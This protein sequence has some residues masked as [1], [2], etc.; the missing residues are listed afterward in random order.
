[1]I[2]KILIP[3]IVGGIIGYITNDIAIKMLFHPRK[4]IYI[5]KYQ[6]PFTPGLIPKE[7]ERIAKSLGRII[8][9]QLLNNETMVKAL[10]SEEMIQKLR[11]GIEKIIE[12]NKSN[13]STV[14]EALSKLIPE[15][16]A[17]KLIVAIKDGA[18][19]VIYGKITNI[20][21]S[22]N[23]SRNILE[24]L[25]EKISI[26]KLGFFAAMINDDIMELIAQNIAD[27][28]NQYIRENGKALIEE[29]IGTE[30]DKIKN[31]PI[32]EIIIKY[33]DKLPKLIDFI[34]EQ[35][36]SFIAK[37]LTSILKGIDLAKVVEEKISEFSME[38]FE[39]MIFAIMKKELNAIVYFGAAL[40]FV[41]GWIQ[42][43]LNGI[44]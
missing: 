14:E 13:T 36:K 32:N 7:R 8:S 21:V 9:E 16:M 38:Q 44:L 10:A 34:V 42:V 18:V 4:A 12:N 2:L 39:D 31:E 30:I 29:F 6:L 37:N 19:N 28:L 41:L 5:G 17:N 23:V 11:G 20:E 24:K 25:K 27:M 40:G 35:Y 26:S 1:M 3:P 15:E 43:L 33:S 22:E